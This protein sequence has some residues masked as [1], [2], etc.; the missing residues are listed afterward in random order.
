M[1]IRP[2]TISH[3]ADLDLHVG[4]D[5]RPSLDLLFSFLLFSFLL[6]LVFRSSFTIEQIVELLIVFFSISC[7][8]RCISFWLALFFGFRFSR[9]SVDVDVV[10]VDL[11][12]VWL[13][14][15]VIRNPNDLT[16]TLVLT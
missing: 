14:V 6:S 5:S 9:L 1:V 4:I 10:H 7:L 3:V 8:A 12:K 11:L 2:A 15:F 13:A 16:F